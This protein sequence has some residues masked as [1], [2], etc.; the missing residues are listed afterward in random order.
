MVNAVPG[1]RVL[2]VSIDETRCCG[3]GNCVLTAPDV[4]DQRAADGV[5][6]V[7]ADPLPAGQAA[8]A[9]AAAGMCPTGA[10]GLAESDDPR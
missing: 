3:S 6:V 9:R 2:R 10:I 7:L 4:F 1:H 5:A 8:Q